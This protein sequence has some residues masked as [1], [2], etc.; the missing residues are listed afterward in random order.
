MLLDKFCGLISFVI[1]SFVADKIC[2][3]M[4]CGDKFCDDMFCMG[5]NLSFLFSVLSTVIR[6]I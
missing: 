5:S 2:F 3:D 6:S 4:F 1:I